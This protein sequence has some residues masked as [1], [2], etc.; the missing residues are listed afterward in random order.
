MIR[1]LTVIKRGKSVQ[2]YICTDGNGNIN[3]SKSALIEQI[4]RGNVEN[5]TVYK[6]GDKKIVRT[7]KSTNCEMRDITYTILDYIKNAR[8]NGKAV[9]NLDG[10]KVNTSTLEI[11]KDGKAS[12]R[13]SSNYSKYLNLPS[14]NNILKG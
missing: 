14:V 4:E 5:A 6:R 8:D 1:V 13:F 7:L 10:I 2:S 9:I 12:S 3:M 11:M